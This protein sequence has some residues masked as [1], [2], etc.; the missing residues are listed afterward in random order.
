MQDGFPVDKEGSIIIEP[1]DQ[2]KH[3]LTLGLIISSAQAQTIFNVC[4]VQSGLIEPGN[5]GYS[6]I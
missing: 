2:L 4:S 5:K 3:M 6:I 1:D